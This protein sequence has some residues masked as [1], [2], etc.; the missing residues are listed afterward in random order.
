MKPVVLFNPADVKEI[1]D[2]I[3]DTVCLIK[4]QPMLSH[5]DYMVLNNLS[6]ILGLLNREEK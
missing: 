4:G 2:K 6:D 5:I 1:K 3:K